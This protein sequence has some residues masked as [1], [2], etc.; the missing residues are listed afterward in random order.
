MEYRTFGKT[1]WQVS[2]IGLGG[3]WFYGRPEMG[4]KPI[5]HGV[6]VI[7]R[8]LELG[9]NYFD[10][11]PLYGRGRSEEVV[12]AALSGVTEPYYLA[13]K[14]GYFPEPF[15]Y[16][17]DAILR[18]LDAS[19]KRLKRD[20]VN[21]IQVHEAEKAGWEGLFG[22]GRTIETLLDLQS[23]GIC[24]FIGLTGSDLGLM[25][26]T[27]Q[28]TD[29]FASVITFCKYDLLTQE[30]TE[31]LVPTAADKNVAVICAS[32]LHAG[33]LG[34]K[35]AHWKDLGRFQDLYGRLD[36]VTHLLEGEPEKITRLALRYLLSDSR[37]KMLLSGVSDIAELED[38]VAVSDGQY[39]SE[40]LI[41]KIEGL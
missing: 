13:T 18:G 22:Q 32:P 19:L 11:A 15:D 26:R 31:E 29:A 25:T 23:Q 1:G 10:T 2:E 21:L 3:S 16:T 4:L 30:A 14:V 6:S 33:L 17:R 28:E 39:L 5:S 35:H 40:E 36:S 27:L 24:D 7:E 41:A 34:S 37:V 38:C 8:A 12:G 9:V 20:R